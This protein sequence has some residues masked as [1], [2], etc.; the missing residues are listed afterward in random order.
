MFEPATSQSHYTDH[1][2]RYSNPRHPVWPI[3]AQQGSNRD[4][5]VT[6]SR[7][8]ATR[9]EPMTSQSHYPDHRHRDSN[10]RPSILTGSRAMRFEPATSQSHYPEHGHRDSDPR[11]PCHTIPITGTEIGARDIPVTLVNSQAPRFEPATFQ[12]HWWVHATKFEPATSQLHYPDH[13]HRDSN[14]RPSSLAGSRAIRF[15]PRLPSHS[16]PITGNEIRTRNFPVI[17]SR[18]QAPRFEPPT[19]QADYAIVYALYAINLHTCQPA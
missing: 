12:A 5:P 19:I 2:H 10:P 15:E 16:I 17:P 7:T 4:F 3:H 11:S 6:L 18:S 13:R 9:F 14:P 1:R 8:Q